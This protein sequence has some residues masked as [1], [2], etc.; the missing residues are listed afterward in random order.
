MRQNATKES[1]MTPSGYRLALDL[2]TNY[3]G[4]CILNLNGEM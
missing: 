2:G 4:W 3:I 1:G